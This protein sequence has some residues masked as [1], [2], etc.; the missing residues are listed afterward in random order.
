MRKKSR[1]RKMIRHAHAEILPLY[2]V[3]LVAEVFH[4]NNSV[5]RNSIQHLA[6][7][8]RAKEQRERRSSGISTKSDCLKGSVAD[9]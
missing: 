6:T 2:R 1:D 8:T 7:F 5:F 9:L 4:L 3:A